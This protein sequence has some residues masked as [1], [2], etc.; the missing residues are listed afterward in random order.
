MRVMRGS[1]RVAHEG[2]R[3]S[4]SARMLRNF[5]NVNG[6]PPRPTRSWRYR[7]GP[8]PSRCT[9]K[10]TTSISGRVN[11][12]SSKLIDMSPARLTRLDTPP[13]RTGPSPAV[14]ASFM[15]TTSTRLRQ[16]SQKRPSDSSRIP[17][18]MYSARSTGRM[19]VR[20]DC[21]R[22]AS[23]TPAA[24]S[25]A[26]LKLA[27]GPLTTSRKPRCPLRMAAIIVALPLQGPNSA[28]FFAKTFE[29]TVAR[30]SNRVAN[31]AKIQVI[32]IFVGQ[33][34]SWPTRR[35]ASMPT[36]LLTAHAAGNASRLPSIVLITM[37]PVRRNTSG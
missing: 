29:R 8:A 20:T 25:A 34:A 5:S 21:G 15:F 10:A 31:T 4:A 2:P 19:S 23:R 22:T 7:T 16:R 26:G 11:S 27:T 13:T 17:S 24:R 12:S 3:N 18:A 9:N 32:T 28:T 6:C 35:S 37:P 36:A 30:K 14:Q 33:K 1:S